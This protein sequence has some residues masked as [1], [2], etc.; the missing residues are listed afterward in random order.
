MS[1]VG[2]DLT[3]CPVLLP[4]KKHTKLDA[5]FL[6]SYTILPY[7]FT[8]RQIFCPGLQSLYGQLWIDLQRCNISSGLMFTQCKVLKVARTRFF[9]FTKFQEQIENGH[10]LKFGQS[11]DSISLLFNKLQPSESFNTW[12]FKFG[13]NSKF[14]IVRRS[15]T[16]CI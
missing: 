9:I 13:S 2:G 6:Q 5:K 12:Y 10:I 8:L 16:E 1:N 3:Q 15:R 14:S 11:R 4:E 7:F